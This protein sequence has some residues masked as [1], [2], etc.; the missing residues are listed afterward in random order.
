MTGSKGRG[1]GEDTLSKMSSKVSGL[2][3]GKLVRGVEGVNEGRLW[4]SV[5]IVFILVLLWL[6]NLILQLSL[7]TSLA[8]A[9]NVSAFQ[10]SAKGQLLLG[11]VLVG[12]YF[13]PESVDSCRVFDSDGLAIFINVAILTN[14]L[15]VSG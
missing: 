9:G 10:D 5:I 4:G 14:S 12:L 6:S 1:S 13:L 3:H 15:I 8:T 2:E 11:I 7:G